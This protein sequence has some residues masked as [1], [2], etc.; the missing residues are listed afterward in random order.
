MLGATQGRIFF[1]GVVVVG[2]KNDASSSTVLFCTIHCCI[3]LF[4]V[5]CEVGCH[6]K[7]T[8]STAII[9]VALAKGIHLMHSRSSCHLKLH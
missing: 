8:Y 5:A 9:F 3:V 2:H 7:F 6:T 4:S 1:I